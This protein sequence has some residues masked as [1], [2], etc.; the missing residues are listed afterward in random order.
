MPSGAA[1]IRRSGKRGTSWAIKWIDAGGLQWWETLGPEPAWSEQKAQRELGKRL[2]AVDEGFRKPDR[3]TFGDFAERFVSDYLPGRKL[4]PSTI[5]N[6]GYMLRGHLLPFFGDHALAEIEARPELIDAY[7]A[8]K[9]R[10]GSRRRRSRISSCSSTSC[11]AA[12]S[13]GV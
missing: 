13:S 8:V 3:V 9:A 6:Y 12:Q 7:I 1:V 11:C 10:E 2:A 5:E 4:K